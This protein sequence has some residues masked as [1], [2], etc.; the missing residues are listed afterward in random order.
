MSDPDLV[1]CPHADRCPGCPLIALE[2]A[3]QLLVKAERV[4]QALAFYPALR[5]LA[6]APVRAAPTRTDYRTRAKLVVGPGPRVGLYAREGHEILDLPHCRVLAPVIAGAAA[7]IRR[8][9]ADPPADADSVLRAEGDGSGRLRALDLR[10]VRDSRGTGLLI[11]LVV[12]VPPDPELSEVAA[13]AE[14]LAALLPSLRGVAVSFHDGRSPQLLGTPPMAVRGPLLH[15]DETRPGAPWTFSAAGSFAQAHRAQSAAIAAEIEAAIAPQPGRR[16]LDV[17]AG[18]GAGSL[19]LAA[20]GAQVTAIEAFEPAVDAARAA[21][22]EQHIEGLTARAE[23]AESALPRL[24]S[25]GE[26]FDAAVVNPPRRGLVPRVREALVAV[27]DGPLLYVSCAPE[28]LARDLAH[29]AWLGRRTARLLPFDLMPLTGE[30]ECVAVLEPADPPRLSVLFEDDDVLAVDKPP[31]LPTVPQPERRGSLL[32]LVRGLPGF[33]AAVPLHRLDVDTSGVCLFAR[34]VAVAGAAQRALADPAA[35]KRYLALVRGVARARGRIARPIVGESREHRA[36]TR[37]RR[38]AVVSG[39]ALLSVAPDAGG[40]GA[41]RL[42]HETGRTHQIRRHLAGIGQ[43]VLGDERYGHAASN[44]HLFERSGLD[45]A[46]LHCAEIELPHPRSGA[47]LRITAPLAPDLRAA[48]AR[49]GG[50]PESLG[51]GPDR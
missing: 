46:F 4:A 42:G 16:V 17:Y 50:D 12:R 25:S 5:A 21:A 19:A 30:V 13:A 9:L 1:V 38:L 3:A 6:P 44:R 20:A 8:L 33:D 37:Y 32:A 22:Q 51:P 15:P 43:P 26:R 29:F 41:G 18:S 7:E 40:A 31:F 28:T 27:C 24:L 34:S 14:R 39:H 23:S 11:T 2:P 47:A 48:F 10:E 49:L 36:A 35:A 45:R